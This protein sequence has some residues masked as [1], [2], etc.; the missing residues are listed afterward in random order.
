MVK[1]HRFRYD[2][3]DVP[4]ITK[5]VAD[6]ILEGSRRGL[7]SLNTT[8]D[9]GISSET[10]Q[11]AC[12][13][14]Y[15]RGLF[16][17]YNVLEEIRHDRVYE[18]YE[19]GLVEVVIRSGHIY[20][21]KPVA[22]DTAPTLEIDGIHMHRIV[23]IT[24]W[25]DSMLKVKVARVSRGHI[26]LDTCMGLGYTAI[27]SLMMGARKIYTVEIDENVIEITRHNPWS[28]MLSD[29]RIEI[30]HGDVTRVIL[31]FEDGF[32]HRIIHDPPRLTPTTGD[33]YSLE[34][35]KELYRVLKP[36]GILFHYTGEPGKHG[37]PKIVKGIGDR[38]RKVGFIVKYDDRVK[39]YVAFKPRRTRF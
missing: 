7:E 29:E 15:I 39:G 14:A 19:G 26:V 34:F 2:Y 24:P 22:K 4:R 18:V 6:E 12:D 38:L 13:G 16:V 28:R 37:G 20:I 8:L 36:G 10:I 30:I 27:H 9:L 33:L 5:W 25:I 11:L 23:D 17:P 31:E 1:I 35:Y 21:L 32:F 3:I